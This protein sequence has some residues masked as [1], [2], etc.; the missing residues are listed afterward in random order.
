[1][2]DAERFTWQ[3]MESDAPMPR[4]SRQ[5]VIGEKAMVSR[6]VLEAGCRVPSHAHENEQISCVLEGE[7]RM[8]V[9]DP[10]RAVT[11]GAGDVLLIPANLPHGAEAM[12]RTVV[13]DVFSP[14]SERTGIDQSGS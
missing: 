8:D 12:Q 11:L 1:M 2:A 9:G 3:E 6:I 13:L 5:R 14:P 10:A 4:L 7:L